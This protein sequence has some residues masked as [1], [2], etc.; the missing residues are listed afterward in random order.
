VLYLLCTKS[1]HHG[2]QITILHPQLPPDLSAID[3]TVLMQIFAIVDNL[4]LVL[5]LKPCKT[6]AYC[7]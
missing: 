7:L 5:V 3:L 6:L 1:P 2:N 4:Y